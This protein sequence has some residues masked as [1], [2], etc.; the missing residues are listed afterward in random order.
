MRREGSGRPTAGIIVDNN[1]TAADDD[2]MFVNEATEDSMPAVKQPVIMNSGG[3]HGGLVQK[4]IDSQKQ[5]T[6]PDKQ[7]SEK[8]P[9]M[10]QAA[11]QKERNLVKKEVGC[12][13]TLLVSLCEKREVTLTNQESRRTASVPSA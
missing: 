10:N 3:Q 5:Y 2:E 1:D 9:V 13:V 11:R 7:S 8:A 4:I 6:G 12:H